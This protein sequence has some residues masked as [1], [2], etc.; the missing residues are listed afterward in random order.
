VVEQRDP[1]SEERPMQDQPQRAAAPAAGPT[2]LIVDDDDTIRG[3]LRACLQRAAHRIVEAADGVEALERVAEDRPTLVVTDMMMPRMGGSELARELRANPATR[4]LPILAISA[5]PHAEEARRA[6]CDA[7]LA[8]PFR[9]VQLLEDVRRWLAPPGQG[10]PSE[11]SVPP[12]ARLL[13]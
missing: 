8:K 9:T 10:P 3:L 7:F 5:G 13:A 6:G 1:E 11:G 4:D 12:V 2:I